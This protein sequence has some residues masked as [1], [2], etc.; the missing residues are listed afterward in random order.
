[1]VYQTLNGKN[2]K[3]IYS[4]YMYVYVRHN[5]TQRIKKD[6]PNINLSKYIN[7]MHVVYQYV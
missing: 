3:N 6:W 4:I 1:M 2:I 5:E 7:F